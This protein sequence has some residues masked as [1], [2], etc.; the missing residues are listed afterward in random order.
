VIRV[1]KLRVARLLMQLSI[2][3]QYKE[4]H[5]K[6]TMILRKVR[7]LKNG[8]KLQNACTQKD[9]DAR[10]TKQNGK[11]YYG[12]RNGI[13]VD[14]QHGIIRRYDITPAN[15]HDSQLLPSLLDP[16]NSGDIVWGDSAFAGRKFDELLE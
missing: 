7:S 12:Y 6:K 2:Q 1:L 10:W 15:V 11:S 5:A 3:F 8:R 16:E 4:I 14:V 9:L 13:C